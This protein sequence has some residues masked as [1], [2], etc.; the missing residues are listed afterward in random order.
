LD[1]VAEVEFGQYASNV[2]LDGALLDDEVGRD[3]DVGQPLG[4]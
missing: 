3:L 1:A 4:N 2:A